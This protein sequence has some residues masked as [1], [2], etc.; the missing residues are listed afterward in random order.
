MQKIDSPD[1]HCRK[2]EAIQT[3]MALASLRYGVDKIVDE[4][5]RGIFID[6]GDATE[7]KM[8]SVE[9]DEKLKTVSSI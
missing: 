7:M 1:L 8:N 6:C 4:L 9:S 2:E 3:A 5:R